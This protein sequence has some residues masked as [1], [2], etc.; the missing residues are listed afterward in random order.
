[1]KKILSIMFDYRERCEM[2]FDE[3]L[4]EQGM[5][6]D[7]EVRR[8]LTKELEGGH[9]YHPLIGAL[10]DVL[11]EFC[12]RGG[13]R[14]AA[15]T[16]L[17]TYEGY[18]GR[19]D[20]SI[21]RV[22]AGVE[23]YR[24]A[25]LVH[26]DLVDRDDMRRGGETVHR[27]LELSMDPRFGEGAAV[28]TGDILFSISLRAMMGSGFDADDM[29]RVV[30][31]MTREY[32]EVNESQVLDLA[33]EFKRP[34]WGEWEIM[35]SRRAASLFRATMLVGAILGGAPAEDIE[36]LRRAGEHIGFA[37]DIQDDIIVTFATKEQ[38][39]RDPCGDIRG[40][41]KPLHI[42][43]TIEKDPEFESLLT[44]ISTDE[45]ELDIDHIRERV[46]KC[47]ALEE[48]KAISR[49]HSEDAREAIGCTSMSDGA[50]EFF[51]SLIK[52]IEDSLEWYR[53]E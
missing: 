28:F 41:K 11:N 16:T 29:I 42:V 21:V 45:M 40:G 30:D 8:I 18:S 47:G 44:R 23:L 5:T 39:G 33:F 24:H 15:G 20:D 4:E 22:A 53:I 7:T 6:V 17:A 2:D 38:D 10:Y 49:A 13:K 26:D 12:M 1:M 34:D 35:A 14:L 36:L 27:M 50:K 46:R 52:Y 51:I 43:L 31:L 3:A 37:F 19:L 9:R 25:I 32:Q 48:A